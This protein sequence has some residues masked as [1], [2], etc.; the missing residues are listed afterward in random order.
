M[1]PG[2]NGRVSDVLK[3]DVTW[4]TVIDHGEF[5]VDSD[6][7]MNVTEIVE[8]AGMPDTIV[9]AVVDMDDV[10]MVEVVPHG[11]SDKGQ[12]LAVEDAGSWGL[13]FDDDESGEMADV[14]P[15]DELEDTLG[16]AVGIG[17]MDGRVG[18]CKMKV[19]VLETGVT[20]GEFVVHRRD[21]L[22]ESI[23]TGVERLVVELGD[24]TVEELEIPKEEFEDSIVD[25]LVVVTEDREL[26]DLVVKELK[27]PGAGGLESGS[28]G[29]PDDLEVTEV[30]NPVVEEP[31]AP[32]TGK[33]EDSVVET[34]GDPLIGDEEVTDENGDVRDETVGDLV[35]DV[36]WELGVEEAGFPAR[37]TAD[38]R[39]VRELRDG[40]VTKLEE[41]ELANDVVEEP[42]EDGIGVLEV[43]IIDGVERDVDAMVELVDVATELLLV[44][45]VEERGNV[46]DA[47]WTLGDTGSPV[48]DWS[49]DS[50]A[51]EDVVER[52]L[53]EDVKNVKLE[54]VVLEFALDAETG[55]TGL[56]VDTTGKVEVLLVDE[57][58]EGVKLID[59]VLE[60][61]PYIDTGATGLT[62]DTAGNVEVDL[63]DEDVN[64]VTLIGVILELVLD[65]GTGAIGLVVDTAGN[66]EVN[67]EEDVEVKNV[68][69]N[70]L[71]VEL[72]D[73][74][75]NDIELNDVEVLEV[76]KEE[77]EDCG[78]ADTGLGDTD[79]KLDDVNVVDLVA[80]VDMLSGTP[81]V[82]EVDEVPI[83]FF[84]TENEV[85]RLPVVDE[86]KEVKEDSG[87]SE[88]GLG[89]DDDK[90]GDVRVVDLVVP[91]GMLSGT[92]GGVDTDGLSNVL[93]DIENE[94]E[95][96]VVINVR[97]VVD[98]PVAAKVLDV[99]DTLG[100]LCG[101]EVLS[102]LDV[103]DRLG[104]P[105][106]IVEAAEYVELEEE[107]CSPTDGLVLDKPVDET[108]PGTVE[109]GESVRAGGFTGVEALYGEVAGAAS[110]EEG[111]VNVDE[112]VLD[113]TTVDDVKGDTAGEISEEVPLR[114]EALEEVTCA[115]DEV[116]DGLVLGSDEPNVA[117]MITEVIVDWTLAE[118]LG[119]TLDGCWDTVPETVDEYAEENVD[120]EVCLEVDEELPD[121][122]K[123]GVA[124][125]VNGEAGLNVVDEATGKVEDDVND[126]GPEELVLRD[127]CVTDGTVNAADLLV[128]LEVLSD[129]L[130]DVL[131]TA[132]VIAVFDVEL[133][134]T[135]KDEELEIVVDGEILEVEGGILVVV[136]AADLLVSV[137][138]VPVFFE[139][140]A[141]KVTVAVV[142]WEV[143]VKPPNALKDDE[144]EIVVDVEILEVDGDTLDIVNAADLLVS[145]EELPELFEGGA[146]K[147]RV[148]VVV[149][150]A[151]VEP[152]NTLKGEEDEIVLDR[153]ILEVNDDTLDIVN[154]A[155]LLVSVVWDVLEVEPKESTVEVVVLDEVTE[156]DNGIGVRFSGL[157]LGGDNADELDFVT[158]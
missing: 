143:D 32:I 127:D 100:V 19:S 94:V 61:V 144:L 87:V 107:D 30:E 136:N 63:V 21:G 49:G 76:V 114:V 146:P 16:S 106:A 78:V 45:V 149:W 113:A 73:V 58:I 123:G 20:V 24:I 66:V 84:D 155:D 43:P 116:V 31:E 51:S 42:I 52:I 134:D 46:W 122:T 72:N 111:G 108:T 26:D 148:A 68:E 70:D 44:L 38:D 128:S 153:E 7:V 64:D 50:L 133:P 28:L 104:I 71:E 142:V 27:L 6:E 99:L 11:A 88:I 140:G 139:A 97:D 117:V 90:V 37:G 15:V 154:A 102:I 132:V 93:L 10:E 9:D 112:P 83:G 18:S 137:E 131:K 120:D 75:L 86:V 40:I 152:P 98:W 1:A 25:E 103:V 80:P 74:E 101:M 39:V 67:L 129:V 4:D 91:L 151:E 8:I 3:V 65:A 125:F 69:L 82:V 23:V 13:V 141:P 62:V 60:L 77:K 53:V 130:E 124:K 14:D 126:T 56:T 33:L 55:V 47:G 79:D 92:P 119:E 115:D 5:A 158:V 150:K 29:S 157:E 34:A 147:T 12:G 145:L 2:A 110:V 89:I 22:D 105:D 35:G 59:V 54:D 118:V 156:V 138:V 81:W 48:E 41:N 85:E 121:T 96:L 36:F 109:V 17:T 95:R 135:L 57:G